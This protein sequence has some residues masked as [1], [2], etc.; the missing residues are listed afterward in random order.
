MRG[1]SQSLNGSD[2]PFSAQVGDDK[3]PQRMG[4]L[5]ERAPECLYMTGNAGV[6]SL[7]AIGFC[8]A[9]DAKEKSLEIAADCA[10]QAAENN[11]AVVSG[12]AAGVDLHAHYECLK[13]GGSTI[14]VLPEGIDHFRIRRQLKEVWDWQRVLVI[15]QFAPADVWRVSRAMARNAVLI[16]L[17]KA[18]IVIEAGKDKKGGTYAAGTETT[19]MGLPLFVVDH[20]ENMQTAA[21]GN[22]SLIVQGGRRLG[23]NKKTGRANMDIVFDAIKEPTLAQGAPAPAGRLWRPLAT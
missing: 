20:G 19:K 14:L 12:N 6:L 22:Y 18:M 23:R 1:F 9:R 3:Y 4:A 10:Q 15:S 5:H 17:S 21:P 11:H 16:A 7:P 2:K 8:G 13:A